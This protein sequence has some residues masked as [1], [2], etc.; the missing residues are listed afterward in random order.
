MVLIMKAIRLHAFVGPATLIYADAPKL[1]L[2]EGEVLIRV[3]ATAITPAQ[4]AWDPTWR[5]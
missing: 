2:K 5:P 4:F 1:Q 3:H